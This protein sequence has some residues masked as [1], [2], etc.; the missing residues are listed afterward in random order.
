M[1]GITQCPDRMSLSKVKNFLLKDAPDIVVDLVHN[2]F[3][4]DVLDR[5][6]IL[7]DSLSRA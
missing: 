6:G 5:E 7:K 1:V 3:I 4:F 2:L